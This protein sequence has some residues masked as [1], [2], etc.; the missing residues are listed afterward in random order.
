[1]SQLASQVEA[2]SAMQLYDIH[3]VSENLVL[4]ILRE[5]YGWRNLRNL[6]ATERAN[7]PGIDLAD[8]VAGIAIQVTATPTLDKIKSTIETF[9]KHG[10]E[11]KYHRVVV[12]VLGRKQASY[13]QAAIDRAAKGQ[14]N[15][16]VTKDILDHRDVCGVAVDA[17]P[18]QLVAALEIVRT[19]MRGGVAARGVGEE[20]FNPTS[21]SPKSNNG[22]AWQRVDD[23][24]SARGLVLAF[25]QHYLSIESKAPPFGGRE[26]ECS[27]LNDWLEDS[28]QPSR[29]LVCGPTARGKSSLLV[30]WSE[31]FGSDS[32]WAIVFVPISLRFGTDRPT[33]FYSILAGQLAAVLGRKLSSPVMD[34]EGFYQGA[35]ADLLNEAASSTR[36]ILIVIDGLDEAQGAGFNSTIIPSS[37]PSNV[38]VLVSARQQ[39]GDAGPNGWLER[40]DWQGAGRASSESL[41]L[42]ARS[43]V[44][45]ILESVGFEPNESI[46]V[47]ADRLFLLSGGEPLLLAL[48]AED[49]RTL[50][51][52]G[53]PVSV[54]ALDGLSPGFEAYFS[55]AFD[56]RQ[57]Q[58]MQGDT[59]AI[60]A[61]LAVLA[62]TFGPIEASDLNHLVCLIRNLPRPMSPDRFIRPLTRF[63]AGGGSAAQ[64]YVLNHPK[65]G[66]FLREARFDA[67]S[68]RGVELTLANWGR[69]CVRALRANP[70]TP[71]SSYVL[72]HQVDHLRHLKD[73]SLDDI[74]LILSDGWRLGWYRLE[75]D[76]VGYADSLRAASGSMQPIASYEDQASRA[77]HLKLT[78]SLWVGSV[79]SQG[80]NIPDELLALGLSDGLVTLRQALNIAQLQAEPNRPG[81]LVALRRSLPNGDLEDLVTEIDGI[82]DAANRASSFARLAPYLKRPLRERVIA[83]AIDWLDDLDDPLQRTGFIVELIPVL[84][85]SQLSALLAESIAASFTPERAPSAAMLL[86][87]VLPPLGERRMHDLA[88]RIVT[89]CIDWIGVAE[90]PLL[91]GEALAKLAAHLS[92]EQLDERIAV[93]LPAVEGARRP[94]P[95]ALPYGPESLTLKS[96]QERVKKVQCALNVLKIR[97]LTSDE[98]TRRLDSAL[99]PLFSQDFEAVDSL[100]FVLPLVKADLRQDI[101]SRC[102]QLARERPSA[103]NRTHALLALAKVAT[104]PL[105]QTIIREGLFQARFIEDEYGRCRALLALFLTL[106]PEEQK[107]AAEALLADF[108]NVGYALHRGEL[109]LQLARHFPHDTWLVKAGIQ[110]I[111]AAQDSGNRVNALLRE[112]ASIPPDGREGV[113]Q[114]VWQ[115]I[116]ART[117]VFYYYS[118]GMA[119]RYAGD[120][121][122]KRELD[123][124]RSVL[125]SLKHN[126]ERAIVLCDIV[127]V[128]KRLGATD[129]V[130]RAFE[131]IALQENPN[132]QLS[133]MAHAAD[134]LPRGD[135]RRDLLRR[136]WFA[137]AESNE[138][139]MHGLIE[140]YAKLDVSDQEVAWPILKA[141][142][143]SSLEAAHS[144][145]RLSAIST[146]ALERSQ[147]LESA[148]S[149]CAG[150]DADHRVPA[151]TQVA[152]ACSS[153]DEKLRV[154]D[155]LT[156]TPSVSRDK[157]LQALSLVAP[158]LAGIG[159]PTLTKS[160]MTDVRQC[161]LWWP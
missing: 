116:A 120:H 121:W 159:G 136:S 130:D 46:E 40:L 80:S 47:L 15:L 26:V 98:Y 8:D 108:N 140:G 23:V 134:V 48:Y 9:L 42:L 142:A 97:N 38:K 37:L 81:F 28:A 138:L 76:F 64:G 126:H 114:L 95:P 131:E 27:R 39:A 86:A 122:T 82:E 101:E 32:T 132:D 93:L 4:G 143:M 33:V 144:L 53:Q 35:C 58:Q 61:T 139:R 56:V 161:A 43:T 31:R 125:Q 155:I 59:E 71:I 50:A 100:A 36:H 67:E 91:A 18:K 19:Y 104:P 25:R 12:Y 102:A 62:S 20:D 14:I 89:Q 111:Q 146:D 34:L 128:A 41:A 11:K 13:S 152:L 118:M 70:D 110:L 151:A 147:L 21:T 149:V 109:F 16:D 133:R 127:P 92:D 5:L 1:M 66:E 106:P 141:K 10:L 135:L 60:E 65:L 24:S 150:L 55:R 7:F 3:K 129:L 51:A 68:L 96:R 107:L 54:E 79:K 22:L 30:H 6:N 73:T 137:A 63:V 123:V 145:A 90:D 157:I 49:L 148:I 113:F 57:S 103:N 83:K 72:R 94:I 115:Q 45:S 112:F 156:A 119:A 69:D 153:Q 85:D 29:M 105:R 87:S 88:R 17:E 158:V 44:V 84:E 154:L 124:A 2:A 160:L 117:D 78:T 99:A 75:Q 74:D 77:L 52:G